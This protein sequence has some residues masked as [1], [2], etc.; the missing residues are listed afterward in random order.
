M[1]KAILNVEGMSCVHCVNAISK[2]VG[3]LD[4]V[5]EVNVDLEKKTVL[6][7]FDDAKVTI[8]TIKDEIEDQGYDVV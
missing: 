8:D 6:V 2:A 4:G 7:K 5:S 3:A 1:E